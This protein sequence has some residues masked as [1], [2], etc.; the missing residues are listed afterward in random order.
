MAN[1]IHLNL[2]IKGDDLFE[3]IITNEWMNGWEKTDSAKKK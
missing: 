1:E 2:A 3:E